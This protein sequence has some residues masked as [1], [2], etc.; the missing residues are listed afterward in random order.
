MEQPQYDYPERSHAISLLAVAR[1]A[2]LGDEAVKIFNACVHWENSSNF[3]W[4]RAQ[5]A[6]QE[7]LLERGISA[8]HHLGMEGSVS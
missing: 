6:L 8:P 3:E 7:L 5:D 2:G 1:R 4:S